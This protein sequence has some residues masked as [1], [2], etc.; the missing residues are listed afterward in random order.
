MDGHLAAAAV[1]RRDDPVRADDLGQRRGKRQ[2][3]ATLAKKR[4]ADDDRVRPCFE[5]RTGALD[6]PDPAADP[7]GQPAAD[8]G[9]QRRV[10]TAAARRPGR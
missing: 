2:I 6:R 8:R 1:D 3:D 5:C 9:R 7:A 10:V 4:R